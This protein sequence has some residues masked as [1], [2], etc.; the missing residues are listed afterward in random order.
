MTKEAIEQ[1]GRVLDAVFGRPGSAQIALAH[2]DLIKVLA[3]AVTAFNAEQQAQGE[4]QTTKN[5]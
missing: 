3:D 4:V 1:L 2:L 5:E